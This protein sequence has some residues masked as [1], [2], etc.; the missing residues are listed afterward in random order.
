MRILNLQSCTVLACMLVLSCNVN[1]RSILDYEKD[2]LPVIITTDINHAGG[3]PDDK[4]SLIHLLWFANELDIRLVVPDRWKGGGYEASMQVVDAYEKDY[5]NLSWKDLRYPSPS[6]IRKSVAVD[7]SDAANRMISEIESSAAPVYLLCWG[8]MLT[9][10]NVL[11]HRPDLSEKIRLI[12]IGTGLKYGPKDE[13]KGD[14]CN[15]PN[16]NG[17]GRN[18]IFNDSQFH[19]MWWLES[20]WTYNGMFMGDGPARILDSLSV[21]GDMGNLIKH[22]VKD[23][24]WAQY[25]RVGD[26][27]SVL[28]LLDHKHDVN[29]PE[30]ESWAGKFKKPFP[31]KRPN[32]F[33]DDCGEINWN[34]GDPCKSWQFVEQMYEYNKSTLLSQRED[35]YYPLLRKLDRIYH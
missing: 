33:T 26:T 31:L 8:N 35:I 18:A 16:W 19:G 25:F 1:K 10:K 3:D 11:K 12:S 5:Q 14:D 20:N 21:Y 2:R 13:V 30:I 28:Y 32:Y 7:S 4:Q 22:A 9:I 27:P 29:N 15:V 34:Y 6:A 23:H 17:K 24:S